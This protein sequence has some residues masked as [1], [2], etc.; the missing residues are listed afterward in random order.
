MPSYRLI[1]FDSCPFVQR[2]A[3]LLQAKAVDYEIQYIDLANKPDWFLELSPLGKVPLLEVDGQT[4]LFESQV[5]AEFLEESHAPRMHPEP[6]LERAQHRAVI[7]L[8]SA[9]LGP[10][11]R[12]TTAE[13]EEEFK[14]VAATLDKLLARLEAGHAGNMFFG[15]HALSL[16]D[17]AAAPLLQ[18]LGWVQ[19][20][21]G[22]DLLGR[23]PR[24][25]TWLETLQRDPT[26]AA[27]AVPDLRE[28]VLASY[29][30]WLGTKVAA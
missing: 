18:R 3:F 19:D 6:P 7:E 20:V 2:A 14:A 21:S 10:A 26:L 9:A 11:W 4:V 16:V 17:A 15:G 27:S 13:T 28:R 30:G 5:I 25:S 22:H 24:L 23:F 12:M 1:S 8:V 29:K